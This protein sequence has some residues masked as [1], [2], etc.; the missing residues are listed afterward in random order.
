M[1]KS[2][3]IEARIDTDLKQAA[4]AV[5]AKLGI[6]PS[7]AIRMFYKQVEIH[8]GFPFD[9]RIPNAETLEALEEAEHYPERMTRYGSAEEMFEA[10]K[11]DDEEC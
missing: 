9:V 8:N 4:E 2:G 6:S 1:S 5:F 3:R 10:W 7:E 11:T